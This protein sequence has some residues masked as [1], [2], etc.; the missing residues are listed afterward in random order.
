M[1]PALE[2]PA[3]LSLSAAAIKPENTQVSFFSPLYLLLAPR[4]LRP[5][6]SRLPALPFL[7]LHGPAAGSARGGRE[8]L[9]P[10]VQTRQAGPGAGAPRK[11]VLQLQDGAG[12]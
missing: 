8:P 1:I 5:A 6:S 4:R 2:V 9:L 12:L 11:G 3:G 10:L 7:R